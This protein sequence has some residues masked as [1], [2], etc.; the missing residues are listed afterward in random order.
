MRGIFAHLITF[1][2]GILVAS[3]VTIASAG[4]FPTINFAGNVSLKGNVLTINGH[5]Q[6]LAGNP[7]VIQLK[8]F[9]V[10]AP[11]FDE[12]FVAPIRWSTT[13]T[14]HSAP[15]STPV[16]MQSTT[17]T[18][19]Q[20]CPPATTPPG[21]A[22]TSPTTYTVTGPAIANPWWPGGATQPTFGSAQA[23]TQIPAG[24]SL[25]VHNAEGTYYQYANT[26]AC[27]ADLDNQYGNGKGMTALT[28]DQLVAQ[29]NGLV[30]VN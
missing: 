10:I 3:T 1:A 8:A 19:V 17:T 20:G 30:T 14:P 26:P 27:S 29:S 23:S 9:E 11:Q 25:T 24:H 4:G 2:A 28:V 16:P 5:S 13:G 15:A 6:Q 7:K 22:L 12:A 18:A 21:G